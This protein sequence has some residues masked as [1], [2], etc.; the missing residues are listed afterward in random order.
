[1]FSK[2]LK[3]SSRGGR[4]IFKE[5]L[6]ILPHGPERLGHCRWRTWDEIATRLELKA[7]RKREQM[8][9]MQAH[10]NA[11]NIHLRCCRKLKRGR[12]YLHLKSTGKEGMV[13]EQGLVSDQIAIDKMRR[14]RL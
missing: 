6:F 7:Q 12:M 8:I 14:G 1:M 4:T 3:A 13:L 2:A 9:S 5:C 11:V 10:I